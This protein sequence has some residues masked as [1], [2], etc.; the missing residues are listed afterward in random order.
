ML[1]NPPISPVTGEPAY[2]DTDP[3]WSRDGRYV[4]FTREHTVPGTPEGSI[5]GS[6]RTIRLRD[7]KVRRITP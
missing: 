3:A 6:I 4:A 5:F 2:E 7:H 1:A